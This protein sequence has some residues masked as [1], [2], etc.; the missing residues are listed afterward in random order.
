MAREVVG[1]MS[2][3]SGVLK[4]ELRQ[5]N[6][7][8]LTLKQLTAVT[9][10]RNP[11]EDL[12]SR[13]K[14]QIKRQRI[15]CKKYFP[16]E[17]LCGL[18]LDFDKVKI[19]NYNSGLDRLLII[20]RGFTSNLGF[21]ACARQFPAW[22]YADDLDKAVPR[23]D[24]NACNDSY[25]V[26]FRDR[27]EA[28]EELKN[29]SANQLVEQG[30][31]GITLPERLWYEIVYWDETGEH[32]DISNWTLCSGSRDVD[33]AVPGV[34]WSVGKLGVAWHYADYHYGHLRARA[35]VPCLPKAD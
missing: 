3:W 29:L 13:I 31:L 34:S 25:A 8:S 28:D 22:R 12:A 19:Q 26:W 15:C 7:G 35:A 20:P 4:D 30:I 21:D 27:Q 11:F 10:H 5:I 18:D 1:S 14:T 33:G 9:E 2:D 6:D 24:R 23:N 17:V 16:K 32:L